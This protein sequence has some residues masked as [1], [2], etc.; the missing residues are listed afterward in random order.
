MIEAPI[1][2]HCRRMLMILLLM[3][4]VGDDAVDERRAFSR[5]EL[6]YMTRT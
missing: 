1:V 5:A 4:G 3:L 6:L 2:F